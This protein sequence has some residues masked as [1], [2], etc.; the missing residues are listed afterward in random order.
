MRT[1]APPSTGNAMPVMK[2][3]SS[4]E[5]K[6]AAFA[7]SQGVPILRRSGTRASRAAATSAGFCG[8][9]GARINRHRGV[10]QS[11]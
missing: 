8:Y 1:R 2:F 6:S 3:A 10:N 7:T 4:D 9:A 5:R 11:G